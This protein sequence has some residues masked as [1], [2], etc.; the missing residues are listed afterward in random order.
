MEKTIVYSC[1]V[2]E[3]AK[4]RLDLFLRKELE[5]YD[6]SREKIKRAIKDGHCSID[7]VSCND[8]RFKVTSGQYIKLSLKV[9]PTEVEPVKGHLDIMYQDDFLAVINKPAGLTVH[10]APSCQEETLVHLLVEH[11]P[12]LRE[13]EGLRPGIVH[14]L[15]KD[16]SGLLC[17]ALTEAA[18]IRLS[19]AFAARNIYKEYLALVQGH[20]PLTGKVE[21]PLGR[22]P[23]LKTKMAVVKNGKPAVS[24]WSVLHYGPQYA[25]VAVRIYTGRTHQIRVHMAYS[26]YPL[27]GDTVYNAHAKSFF[28]SEQKWLLYAPH[29]LL[30]AWKLS[31]EHPFTKKKLSFLCPPPA[32]FLQ[33]AL[34]GEKR[35]QRIVITGVAGCG[36]STFV[37]HLSS[38]GLPVWNAD[39][40][41]I[42]LY[43][44]QQEAWQVLKQRY[45][46][47]F[48]SDDASPVDRKKLAA[49]FLPSENA[50]EAGLLDIQELEAL[51]HPIILH[52][53][54]QY[55]KAQEKN[56]AWAAIAEV[57]L[58]FEVGKDIHSQKQILPLSQKTSS[59]DDPFIVGVFCPEQERQRRLLDI[60]G[61]SPSL[62]ARMDALQ[63]SQE[64]KM[65]ACD[66]VISN[67]GTAE[68]LSGEAKRFVDFLKE[69]DLKWETSFTETWNHL[70]RD[71][72][73]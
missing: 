24:E 5:S 47:R 69:R 73:K 1:R 52:D 58:W 36:K 9:E 20:P 19:E 31:F 56:G 34:L 61:W 66:L 51:L 59:R 26:G 72:T 43:E 10:P 44:P 68:E 54:E 60:R 55:W 71:T 57:P 62:M 2:P 21:A 33:A 25:L 15:D 12:Q 39:Q 7:E 40:A 29:Q 27:L 48:I 46:N 22:H 65:A 16:T 37:N 64:R 17:V 38:L 42:R 45:G 14:R 63:W 67:S 35:M 70:V 13:Q 28:R 3:G 41:V 32:L 49:A 6:V 11:F 4:E 18:R 8:V 53:L 50:D 30:H 23:T